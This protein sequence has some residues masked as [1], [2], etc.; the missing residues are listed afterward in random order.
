MSQSHQ[1]H[2]IF[3]PRLSLHFHLIFHV[4]KY[5]TTIC[6]RKYYKINTN[7]KQI[8][9]IVIYLKKRNVL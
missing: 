8:A 2:I 7:L 9:G 1:Y 6:L 3:I 4:S 5:C